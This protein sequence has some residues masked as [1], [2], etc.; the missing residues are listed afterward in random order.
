MI[1]INFFTLLMVVVSMLIIFFLLQLHSSK[2]KSI[3]KKYFMLNATSALIWCICFTITISTD[4]MLIIKIFY[5]FMYL[6]T[7]TV[8]IFYFLFVL[9]YTK[10]VSIREKPLLRLLFIPSI[11]LCLLVFTNDINGGLMYSNIVQSRDPPYV[12][13]FVVYGPIYYMHYIYIVILVVITVFILFQTY[14]STPKGEKQYRRQLLMIMVV[15]TIPFIIS[16]IRIFSLIPFVKIYDLA[17]ASI[18]IS[19]IFLFLALYKYKFL[20]INPLVQKYIFDGIRDGLF[21]LDTKLRLLSLNKAAIEVLEIKSDTISSLFGNP[22]SEII[23][24]SHSQHNYIKN[25]DNMVVDL[26]KVPLDNKLYYEINMEVQK[27]GDNPG[28]YFYN[29]VITPILQKEIFMGY[30]AILRDISDSFKAQNYLNKKNNLQELIIRLLSHDLANHIQVLNFSSE[31]L[32]RAKKEDE[33]KQI[34]QFIKVKIEAINSL[35]KDVLNFLRE[36][37]KIYDQKLKAYDLNL[38]IEKTIKDLEPEF[39]RK[40]IIVIF[41]KSEEPAL[42]NANITIKSAIF[43]ILSNAIKFSPQKGKI[44]IN[45]NTNYPNVSLKISDQGKGIPDELKQKVFDPFVSYGE[46]KGTG[47]GLTIVL[48]AVQFFNGRV[49]IED[50]DPIG[51]I[52]C[53]ELPIIV[54]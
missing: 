43:N 7:T 1:I 21:V 24:K 54:K 8:S 13:Y 6:G 17:P 5:S 28:T 52:I 42:I 36:E 2:I 18:G 9:A 44:T 49:W 26:E 38:T 53:L 39:N 20:D 14:F 3:A 50:N 48:E 29:I 37:E 27:Y 22:F 34:N 15:L 40:D 4:E 31:S 32:S 30:I 33:I 11:I 19:Y 23:K 35:T 12:G 10:K 41:D 25:I 45:I 51:T 47:L 16:I 46:E